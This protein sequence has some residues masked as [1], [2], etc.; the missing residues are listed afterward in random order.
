MAAYSDN[1]ATKLLN[2]NAKI[3]DFIKTFTD[4]NM[5]EPNVSERNYD[6][7]AKNISEFFIVFYYATYISKV[8]SEYAM[9]LLTE[10][11]F[12]EGMLKELPATVKVAHKF[13]EWG[14]N[15]MNL[16]ELHETGIVYFQNKPYLLT[17]AT[18]GNNSKDLSTV[19]SKISKLVYDELSSSGSMASN[20]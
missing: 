5:P 15:R 10:C 3:N 19:I 8:N 14:D 18:K 6:I 7:S 16:H 11:D 1:N 13:G 12:K 4:L 9:E 2:E 20:L 17:V